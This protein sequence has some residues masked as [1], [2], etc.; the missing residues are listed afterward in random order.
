MNVTGNKSLDKTNQLQIFLDEY[1]EAA[2]RTDQNRRGGMD[3]LA[4]P[5]L[6][7]FGEVGSVLSELKKK[8]RDQDS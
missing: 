5:L 1:Q 8:Q 3:G 2:A 4:F 6:G 7:L